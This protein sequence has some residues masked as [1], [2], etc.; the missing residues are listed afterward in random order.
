MSTRYITPEPALVD[1][2]ESLKACLADLYS[3]PS[4]SAIAVDLEGVDLG[5]TGKLSLMQLYAGGNSN[6]VWIVDVTT[7][8]ARAFDEMDERGNSLRGLLESEDIKKVCMC[9][10]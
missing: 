4:R 5:R 6:T 10:Q 9:Y 8:G 3:T 2:S 7:L 1:D